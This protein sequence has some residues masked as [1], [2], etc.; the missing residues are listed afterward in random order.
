MYGMLIT[1][2]KKIFWKEDCL[3]LVASLPAISGPI[4]ALQVLR[5]LRFARF[6]KIFHAH[7]RLVEHGDKQYDGKTFQTFN[8][9]IVIITI[10]F[11]S[12]LIF[13]D[14]EFGINPKVHS[15]FDAI[16][17]SFTTITTT[18]YGDIYPITIMGR[19][20]TMFLMFF[21]IGTFAVVI[22]NFNRKLFQKEEKHFKP[23]ITK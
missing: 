21:G 15:F 16:W 20:A 9:I 8:I 14:A 7:N 11:T 18:G 1:S 3:Q 22:T 17:W 19:L 23:N 6:A 10:M 2:N 5:F 13:F 12:S 4:Q